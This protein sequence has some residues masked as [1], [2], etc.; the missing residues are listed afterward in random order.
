LVD[1]F[2]GDVV[3][4]PDQEF[5]RRY[6][7]SA[8]RSYLGRIV[9]VSAPEFRVAGSELVDVELADHAA[10]IGS[11]T[12]WVLD[13][14]G[15]ARVPVVSASL[16]WIARQPA[17]AVRR[18]A[19]IARH[20]PG[21]AARRLASITIPSRVFTI[22]KDDVSTVD[23]EP[24]LPFVEPDPQHTKLAEMFA[25]AGAD[26]VVEHGVV[27][28]EVAGL[29][30]AR[31]TDESGEPKI[32][33][34]VGTHDRETF[35]LVH[36]DTATIDQLRSV[37]HTVA[38][39]RGPGAAPHPLNLLARERAIRH[40]AIVDPSSFGMGRLVAAEPPVPRTNVKDDAPCCAIGNDSDGEPV[41]VTFA[42]GIDLDLVPF[43][44]DARNRLAS[45]ARVVIVT[46]SRNVVSVQ[47]RIAELVDSP[48]EFRGA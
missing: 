29:E 8:L 31:I 10:A 44:V 20:A 4:E 40:R 41:V 9:E 43:A 15:S 2:P 36:G 38:E 28:A 30:V 12:L 32:R 14:A 1:R 34:G 11:G 19:V 18:L 24:H 17:G 3:A 45:G 23:A 37:V 39:R 5:S 35:R 26:T 27:A 16:A 7:R 33:I 42:S 22:N 47:L 13:A 25:M 48:V 21:V 46:E 6:E